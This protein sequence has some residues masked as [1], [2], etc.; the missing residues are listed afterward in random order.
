MLNQL[1]H[2]NIIQFVYFFWPGKA[3]TSTIILTKERLA[4]G[5]LFKKIQQI[6]CKNNSLFSEKNFSFFFWIISFVSLHP[7][8]HKHFLLQWF[9][10][11]FANNKILSI[12]FLL[13]FFSFF[14]FREMNL[15]PKKNFLL[16]PEIFSNP[17]ILFGIF[18]IFRK[19]FFCI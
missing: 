6:K 5:Y 9:W 3:T 18:S 19:I 8:T 11:F 1:K 4:I 10:M 15:Y 12:L 16:L 17:I 13:C 2:W 7:H 14:I